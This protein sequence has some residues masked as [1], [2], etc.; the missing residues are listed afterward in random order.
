MNYF[1]AVSMYQELAV[2]LQ[3]AELSGKTKQEIMEDWAVKHGRK[4]IL[5]CMEAL[6]KDLDEKKEHYV[7]V[8]KMALS[9][10]NRKKNDR[11]D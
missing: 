4:K 11:A 1:N 9:V 6:L 3:Y 2:G 8:G 7:S 5:E 10:L